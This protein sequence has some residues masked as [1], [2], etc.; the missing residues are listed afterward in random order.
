VLRSVDVSEDQDL[1]IQHIFRWDLDKTYLRTEFDSWRD[2]IRTALTKPE[3]RLNV[4]GADALMREITRPREDGRPFVSFISGSPTQM[5][6][7]LEQKFALDGVKPDMFIL[8]PQLEY[9]IRGKFK[10]IRGQVGYKLEA[11]L[12]V[13]EMTPLAPE[14][15]FGDDAEQDAFIYSL[16]GDVAAERVTLEQLDGILRAARVYPDTQTLIMERAAAARKQDT[17]ARIFINLDR[18]SAPGRFLVFG[19]RVVPISN[20]FQAALMLCHD[21]VL[22]SAGL[23]RVASDMIRAEDYGVQDLANSFQD[24]CRRGH[25]PGRELVERVLDERAGA[26]ADQI[27]ELDRHPA[28]PPD[29]SER[30]L[31]RLR[32]LAPRKSPPEREWAGPPDYLELLELDHKLR[33][34]LEETPKPK[35]KRGLF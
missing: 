32:A 18:R 3:E 21:R 34:S 27:E 20:Y 6:R 7:T 16:Y 2:L 9:L 35:K 13:R 24:L 10:A 8:K 4:P 19:P 28:L 11:L 22:S 31:T 23:L 14:F 1:P 29:F 25:L 26:L 5:R 17:V 12:R 33:E 30:L 15:C